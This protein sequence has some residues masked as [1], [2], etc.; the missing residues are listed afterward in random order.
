MVSEPLSRY[1]R[2]RPEIAEPLF[3]DEGSTGVRL[4]EEGAEQG[5]GEDPFFTQMDL[6]Q[7]I[8]AD[9]HQVLNRTFEYFNRADSRGA[10]NEM[11]SAHL[12]RRLTEIEVKP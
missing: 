4:E 8:N 12:E 5:F 3:D 6:S 7:Y 1:C 11:R 9:D 2:F 10:E